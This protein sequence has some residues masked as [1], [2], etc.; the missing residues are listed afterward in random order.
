[1]K[2]PMKTV[3][4]L[5]FIMFGFAANAKTYY[6]SNSGNDG[7]SGINPS[8]PW[9]TLTKVNVTTFQPGDNI[10]F[11][12]GD[13]FYGSI[14]VDMSGYSSTPVTY[15]AYGTGAKPTITGF[16]SVTSW[17]NKGGNIWE[18]SN[19]VSTLDN[20]KTVVINGQS[21]PMGRYPNGDASYPFLPNFFNF[22]SHTG[23][24][25]GASSVTTS[26]LTDGND[27]TGADVVIRMNQ[28]T[29]HREVISSQSG[30]TL[31]FNGVAGSLEDG[32][33]FFI[34]NDI[35][36]L[37]QQ[38]EWYYNP[39]TKKISIYSTSMPTN[40]QVSTV[41]M[42]LNFYSNVPT[43]TC[44]NVDNLRFTGAN[45]N[46]VWISGNLTFSIT[47]CDVSYSGLEGMVLYGGGI[48]AGTIAGNSFTNNGSGGIFSIGEVQNLTI[49]NNSIS[50]SGIISAYKQN[51]YTN[52][53]MTI[54]GPNS[55]IQY[56]TVDSSA[57]CGIEFKGAN[58]QVRNNFVNH[59][60]LIRGD[61]GGIYTGFIN[62]TGKVIDGNIVLNSEGN[63]RGARSNDYFAM[64]IYIDDLGNNLSV[65]NNTIA[66]CRTAGLYLH[67]ANN[68][69]IRN[70]TIYNCG[71]LG[72]EV[73][74]A[75][76]GISLDGNSNQFANTV[77]S[78]TLF[79]NIVFATNQYQYALNY[80]A[81]GGGGNYVSNFGT[82]DSNYYVKVNSAST[83]I[84]SQQPAINGNMS[85]PGWQS[86]TGKD[87]HSKEC[88]KTITDLKDVRFEYNLTAQSKTIALDANYLD[89]KGNAYNGSVLLTPYSSVVLI[90][91]G[92]LVKNQPPTASA[93]S[94]QTITLP[95]NTVTLSGSG[96][97]SD[98]TVA[99]YQWT[100][101]SGP[102][103]YTISNTNSATTS[104]KGLI[105][106]NYVF[107][108]KV[109]DNQGATATDS[110]TINVNPAANIAPTASAG[111]NQSITLPTNSITLNGSGIDPDG[112]IASYLWTK[113]SGPSSYTISNSSSATTS[114]KG[115]IAGN[116]VFKLAV[117]DDQGATGTSSVTITVNPAANIAPTATAGSNQSIT[118]P[119]NS[120]T[121]N[122]SGIDS[123]G[124]IASYLW[125]KVSGPSTYAISNASSAT[126][127]VKGLIA[128]V[129]VFKLTV[130]DNQ[131]ATAT[132]SVS[133]TVI[134]AANIAPTASAGSSQ[135]ITLP[136]N[137]ITL[138]GSGIDS[139]G[140]IASYLW[141]KVSGPSTYTI[142]SASSAT[143]SVKG[144]I[145]GN[146]VFK[147]IVTDNQGA[148]ATDSVSITVIPAANIAPT[149][150]AGSNQ[151]ITLPTNSI[152]LNGSGIDSDGTIAS[153]LWTKVSGPSTYTISNASSATTS[154]KGLIAGNYVFKLTVTD[155]Q[156]ATATASV[157]IT[158]NPAANIAPTATA[159]SNQSITLPTNTVTLNGSGIDSDGTIA[160]YLW[161][162]VSGPSTYTI[163]NASSAT[164]SVK[165]LVTGNYVFKLTVT[166]NQGATGTASVTI[167]VNPAA[168]IP[169]TA[170]A[171]SDQVITLP[172]NSVI[173]SGSGTD[174]DGS[175]SSYS[176]TKISGPS[177]FSIKNSSSAAS[178]VSGLAQGVYQFELKVTDDKGAIGKD[179]IQ[180][181]VNAA[182]NISPKA[183]AGLNQSITLPTNSIILN[184]SGVDSDGTIA[185][186]LW[187]KISGPSAYIIA[188]P[189]LAASEV[190]GLVEG[191]YQFELKVTDDKGAI[192]TDTMQLTVNKNNVTVT[193]P[194]VAPT[195][196]A[197]NDTTVLS[198]VNSIV[199]NGSAN[200]IDGKITGYLWTQLSGPSASIILPNNTVS[201]T[202]SSLIAGTY[203]FELK[204]TDNAGGEARD[205]V[206]VTI[207]LGRTAQ[208]NLTGLKVYPNPVHNMTN[209]ELN[210]QADNSRITIKISDISG[211]IVYQ[212]EFVS[213]TTNVK[214]QIDMS[215]MGKGTYVVTVLVDGVVKESVKVVKM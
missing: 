180:I 202:I 118:L 64:G 129:Y 176:W 99:S 189:S 154:V 82:I 37:D 212:K 48:K 156:G 55:L 174:S 187:T 130:T 31:N 86:Q 191:V 211:N 150:S 76:G 2:T 105:A 17:I 171:G 27:W 70:N 173:L 152:T 102:S 157:T 108:L 91:N 141:T 21:V 88:V 53:G 72:T 4:L 139:D 65:T 87:V 153:Y 54:Y 66:N 44:L 96:T 206:K 11:R 101:V 62:E 43:V 29:F 46:G 109:T 181:T 92:D 79:S 213:T 78:N 113:V 205:T 22:Q 39:S 121:L 135:S 26:S 107:K 40:V 166:D 52:G 159:G 47:N 38:N 162:K 172:I 57:Y 144:L 127:S 89:V 210:T 106:G 73:M 60:A 63:P 203:E 201:T 190:S 33:G 100:K 183:N 182:K 19:T 104:V 142:S 58:V 186:Y 35:R 193:I 149:A 161:T 197:G 195:V 14:V 137:S 77:Y 134:P 143:T 179:T 8:S 194:N 75:N 184:G 49:T 94:S 7:N 209:V 199:L 13:T 132:D 167:T 207:A 168:N 165:G 74:W 131:E 69:F 116:Y 30:S 192:G 71:A 124:T 45:T 93:G 158:V 115:L 215:S 9:Q 97:D 28:W 25:S 12:R 23:S 169:P 3:L 120:I 125:T 15:G 177:S 136:T 68:L 90:K 148:T 123:D 6:I 200:D 196:Y 61:A 98:G 204:V 145:A 24:G 110:L 175:I 126:T 59:S 42:L 32:W 10:L 119:T 114:V 146:Y 36:T 81:E 214:K 51:D 147:L 50:V 83:A 160:S 34:Q 117:T 164:T 16:S 1:M 67:N 84:K 18:S 140:T 138:N 178:Q 80:Y 128:G 5:S 85:L 111:S 95:T 122:G 163:S 188:N 56:N 185:A 41:D 151:S 133:I 20:I 103:S 198:P 170:N 112:M 155:D 208:D